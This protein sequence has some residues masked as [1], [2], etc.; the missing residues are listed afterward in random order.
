MIGDWV[1]YKGKP[2]TVNGIEDNHL[3]LK[4]SNGCII[5][6]LPD[7]INPI[8]ITKDILTKNGFNLTDMEEFARLYFSDGRFVMRA[9]YD[10]DSGEQK[11]WGYFAFNVLTIVDYIHQL[12]H[13]LRLCGI[14]KD[15]VL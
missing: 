13:A 7:E 14:D 10:K 5:M 3:Y 8:P 6:A 2:H 1:S 15:I 9:M 11:G 4:N 12:Q